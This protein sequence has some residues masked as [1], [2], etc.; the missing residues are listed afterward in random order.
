VVPE[1]FAYTPELLASF[2]LTDE[3]KNFIDIQDFVEMRTFNRVIRPMLY[4]KHFNIEPILKYD[5]IEMIDGV[6]S[7]KRVSNNFLQY[8][9]QATAEDS[10]N[11]PYTDLVEYLTTSGE[12]VVWKQ[13]RNVAFFLKMFK[14][15]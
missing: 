5:G 2:Y 9:T 3:V 4:K 15:R 10:V 6:D 8:N 12:T 7:Y 11:I 13:D 1:F 14:K